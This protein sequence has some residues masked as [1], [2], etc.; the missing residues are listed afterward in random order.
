MNHLSLIG[1]IF[2]REEE[3]RLKL[4]VAIEARVLLEGE[5]VGG[6]AENGMRRDLLQGRLLTLISK[7]RLRGLLL[8]SRK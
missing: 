4:G 8:G 1:C 6:Y 5:L 3:V 7:D 2:I